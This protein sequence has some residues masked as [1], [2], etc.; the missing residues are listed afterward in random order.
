[1]SDGNE[2]NCALCSNAFEQAKYGKKKF[3]RC[4]KMATLKLT[5]KKDGYICQKCRKTI[6]VTPS[7]RP[8]AKQK[9][10]VL[11]KRSQFSKP[12]TAS[13]LQDFHWQKVVKEAT[14]TAAAHACPVNIHAIHQR[15]ARP[16]QERSRVK[17][18]MKLSEATKRWNMRVSLILAIIL[19]SANPRK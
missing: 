10:A 11:R 14:R 9:K 18:R 12:F 3:L 5:P 8:P 15:A 2:E 16:V 6:K 17:R 19:Y 4:A 13:G 7:K 1:E